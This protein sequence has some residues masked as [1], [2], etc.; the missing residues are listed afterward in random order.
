MA[1]MQVDNITTAALCIDVDIQQSSSDGN[2]LHTLSEYMS[3]MSAESYSD[4]THHSG[5]RDHFISF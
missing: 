2:L 5:I 4:S 3:M 1:E